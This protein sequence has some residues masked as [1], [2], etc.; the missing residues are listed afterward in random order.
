MALSP[1]DRAFFEE[2]ISEVFGVDITTVQTA[3]KFVGEQQTEQALRPVKEAWGDNFDEH[4]ARTKEYFDT[5]PADRQ[6]FFDNPDGLM[7]LFDTQVKPGLPASEK[8]SGDIPAI[9]SSA[10][11][12][13]SA[14]PQQGLTREAINAMSPTEYKAASAEIAQFYASQ[15]A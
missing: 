5:L 10:T 1:E 12:P 8:P 7:Y 15:T 6:A 3:I 14:T 2:A 11:Q 13:A 4:F 9:P